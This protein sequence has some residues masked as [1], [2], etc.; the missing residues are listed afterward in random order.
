VNAVVPILLSEKVYSKVKAYPNNKTDADLLI[1]DI[2]DCNEVKE[3]ICAVGAKYRWKK[4]RPV[5]QHAYGKC[6][7]VKGNLQVQPLQE[8]S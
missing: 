6:H 8:R 4:H 3:A 7:S 5:N 2:T 1:Q